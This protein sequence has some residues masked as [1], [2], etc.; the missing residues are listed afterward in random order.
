MGRRPR[1]G[2]G[3]RSQPVL[4]A[5]SVV[6]S[7]VLPCHFPCAYRRAGYYCDPIVRQEQCQC[8]SRHAHPRPFGLTCARPGAAAHEM[9]ARS[10]SGS[11]GSNGRGSDPQERTAGKG[12]C[13][14]VVCN[15]LVLSMARGV[16][17]AEV[18]L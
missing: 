15:R 8:L 3:Q 10:V 2:Q 14:K 6:L 12:L 9:R 4:R 1:S 13:H 18:E 16:G 11:V 5:M 17:P 7:C